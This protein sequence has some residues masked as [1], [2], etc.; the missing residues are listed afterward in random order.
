MRGIMV[1]V[2]GSGALTLLEGNAPINQETLSLVK[3]A[4]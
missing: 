3:G 2:N 4:I 1:L